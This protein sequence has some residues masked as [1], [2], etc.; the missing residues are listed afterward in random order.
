M[1]VKIFQKYRLALLF[2][3]VPFIS[4]CAVVLLGI[5]AGVGTAAYVGGRLIKT[6]EAGYH[7]TV[8]AGADTLKHLKIPVTE[9]ISDQLKTTF[10]AARPDGTPVNIDIVVIDD[11]H[12][13]VG[14]R[15]GTVGLWD[16]KV[17]TQ[18]QDFIGK[19]LT[20]TQTQKAETAKMENMVKSRPETELKRSS[21]S[22]APDF[23]LYFKPNS[24][25][26]SAEQMK[27]LDNIVNYILEYILEVPSAKAKLNGYTDSVGDPD[28]NK[29]ISEVRASAIKF[30][31]IGKGIPSENIEV[32]GYGAKNF[33]ST[34][35][36]VEGRN[37]NRR[38]EI[39]VI[40]DIDD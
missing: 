6:Y 13:Q 23:T 39:V 16:K 9:K 7:E 8:R 36:T 40:S 2:L 29:M 27:E 21:A 38:V 25:E 15:T 26:L 33:I 37:K 5:G 35:S 17:S 31:L 20:M 34:N 4:G 22:D 3:I 18:I 10:K 32:T 19:Q 28:Y 14:V 24:N 11:K 30:Y 1:S 12:T